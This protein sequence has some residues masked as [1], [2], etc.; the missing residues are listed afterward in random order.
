MAAAGSN[1][2][3]IRAR[4]DKREYRRVVLPNALECLLISDADTDKAAACMEVG[5][6]SFSDPDGLEGLAHFLEHMLFYASEKYPGEQDYTKYISEHGGSCNA[7]TCCETTDFYF[8]V[9]VDNF[10]EALDR[11]AQFFIKP[12]MSQDAVLREIK[13]VDSE[14][15]KNLLSDT[16]RMF[17]LQKHLAS[18]DHPYHKFSTGS[19]ET[20]ETKPKERGLDIRLELLKLYENYSANLMH[21]VVYGKESLDCIQSLVERLFSD[22]KNTDQRSFKCPSQPVLGEHLQLLVKAIPIAESDYLKIS[23]PVTP[24]IHFYKEGPCRYLSHLIGHEGEGS[25]FHIIKELGWAMN[26]V[27]GEGS[28]STQ[29]SF[30]SVSMRLT[31]AGHEHV[32]DIVG[33]VFKYL[34]LLKEEGIHEWIFNELVV[35]NETEFHYQ[36]KVHPISYVTDTVSS[37]RVYFSRAH[38]ILQLLQ[39]LMIN[40]L[41]C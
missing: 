37:M 8:D 11:F 12:L 28:D 20:L 23:W 5:V 15:K 26:L 1:V 35:M 13:A 3:F 38:Y 24:N 19:W 2:E 41:H 32:E 25:I 4:S 21:L 16:W 6:G 7:Y 18:K 29:Y 14:H 31:D 30:F 17:Q 33:L 34:L 9:N 22:V 27:A 36:D 40:D 39:F 10:E